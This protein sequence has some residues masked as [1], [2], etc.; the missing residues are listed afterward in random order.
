MIELFFLGVGATFPI[1][2]E[3]MP[4]IAIRRLGEIFIFDFGENCQLEFFKSGLGVNKPL[5]I[6]ISHMHG[7]HFLGIAPFLQTL[8]LQGRKKELTIYGPKELRDHLL[9]TINLDTLR[10]PIKIYEVKEGKIVDDKEYYIEAINALHNI[11]A[12]SYIFSEKEKPGKFDTIKAKKLGIPESPVR[13]KLKEGIPV[14]IGS[15]I[16]YPKDVLGPPK[17]GVKISYSGDTRY[18]EK[19]I[20]KAYK[21]DVLIHEA[22]FSIDDE[23]EAELTG[24]STSRDAAIVAKRSNSRLLLLTHISARY[25]NKNKLLREARELFRRTYIAYKGLK[26][27]IYTDWKALE[28]LFNSIY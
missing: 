5:H 23:D 8:S 7:D 6:F 22:T 13:K 3:G 17:K 21:S 1:K 19:F 18:N 20:E 16:I 28:I 26:L 11:E 9:N 4:C 2:G 15:K 24:H 10:F 25:S 14:K 27:L 12:F